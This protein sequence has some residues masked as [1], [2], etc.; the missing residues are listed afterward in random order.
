[1]GLGALAAMVAAPRISGLARAA[2]SAAGAAAG[3]AK[4]CI[5]LFMHGGASQIDTF[6]PKPGR[7]TE[8][9]CW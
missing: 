5:V 3:K 7:E 9:R 8:Q 4:A 2:T 1:M 6:D